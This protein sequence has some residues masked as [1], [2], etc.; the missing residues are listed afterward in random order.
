[1][2]LQTAINKHNAKTAS[3]MPSVDVIQP[4]LEYSSEVDDTHIKLACNHA[5]NNM[6][7]V[8]V[9][10]PYQGMIWRKVYESLALLL[11]E[12]AASLKEGESIASQY[13]E[14]SNQVKEV[15]QERYS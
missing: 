15:N 6:I 7:K 2:Q 14:S 11:K 1:M 9:K 3:R 4:L 8:A 5:R 13:H 12:K 10:E